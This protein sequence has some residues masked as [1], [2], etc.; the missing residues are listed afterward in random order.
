MKSIS[1]EF[2]ADT[3]QLLWNNVLFF[4]LFTEKNVIRP[5]VNLKL[6]A[7]FQVF[8]YTIK[9]TTL[10]RPPNSVLK[11]STVYDRGVDLIVKPK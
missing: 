3:G 10:L 5:R 9:C 4:F 8:C 2:L 1:L 11:E 7:K 6:V